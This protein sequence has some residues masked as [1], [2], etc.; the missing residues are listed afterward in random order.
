SWSVNWEFIVPTISYE[1]YNE[2]QIGY[3]EPSW[4]KEVTCGEHAYADDNGNC[5]CEGGY[6]GDAY[7]GCTAIPQETQ[8]VQETGKTVKM[9]NLIGMPESDA[10]NWLASQ[11]LKVNVTY[12][13]TEEQ[14]IGRVKAQS[15]DSGVEVNVGE[16]ITI[17]VGKTAEHQHSFNEFVS[18]T[19]TC[20]SGGTVTYK[21]SCGEVQNSPSDPLGHDW[22]VVESVVPTCDSGGYA[23]YKCSRCND[24]GW[25]ENYDPI[26][27]GCSTP[28]PT[29]STDPEP[30]GEPDPQPGEGEQG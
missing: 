8:E 7:Q 19:A 12:D 2:P 10:R 15:K 13:V 30:S 20:T 21:C 6:E 4:M 23:V 25:T 11:G 28:E 18:N 22:I 26:T 5:V 29:P 16:T 27:E 24:P 14:F 3:E 9:E 17:L 1:F